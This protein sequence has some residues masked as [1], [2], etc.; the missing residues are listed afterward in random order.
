MADPFVYVRCAFDV[1]PR[2]VPASNQWVDLTPY[3]RWGAETLDIRRGRSNE[4]DEVQTGVCT[5]TLNNMDKRFYFDYSG[6]P[7]YQKVHAAKRIEVYAA[8]ETAPNVFTLYRQFTGFA[9]S[10]KPEYPAKGQ[11]AIVRVRAVDGFAHLARVNL[12][13]LFL[14]AQLSGARMASIL[15]WPTVAW[16]SGDTMANLASTG[17]VIVLGDPD[18]EI[19]TNAL[20]ELKTT[21]L[22][23]GGVIFMDVNG[24]FTFQG[25]SF[26]RTP[27]GTLPVFG[28]TGSE[29][30]YE[31]YEP[32][33]DDRMIFNRVRFAAKAVDR[34]QTITV[35]GSSGTITVSYK[36][37]STTQAY[38]VST[39]ALA[40]ALGNLK[41]L[42]GGILQV[43]G[44]PGSSYDIYFN[45]GFGKDVL[46]VSGSGGAT[47]TITSHT[48]AVQEAFDLTS[49]TTYGTRYYKNSDSATEVIVTSDDEAM[50]LANTIIRRYKDQRT[51]LDKIS[52]QGHLNPAAWPTIL[53]ADI[54]TAIRTKRTHDVWTWQQDQFIEGVNIKISHGLFWNVDWQLSPADPTQYWI[55]GDAT[56]G[57][58]GITNVLA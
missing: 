16:P 5:F 54:G 9:E 47:A 57:K 35:T 30:R 28:D 36:G 41:T 46:S 27:T 32:S 14:P 49:M 34:K 55:L 43:T 52:P 25:R 19:T 10:W 12:P 50:N 2:T 20:A 11:D 21:A 39:D 8:L 22:A 15:S 4:L 58:L 37:K 13:S 53:S 48:G 24:K 23:E 42:R 26:R 45:E 17:S 56:Y 7:Y 31:S 33:V 38:N 40:S 29:Y 51:R 18:Y 1:G 6:G 44:T 3:I